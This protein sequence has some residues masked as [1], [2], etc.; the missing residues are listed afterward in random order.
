MN[1]LLDALKSHK[2]SKKLP[3]A[4]RPVV[5]YIEPKDVTNV[6]DKTGELKHTWDVTPMSL[7]NLAIDL[8][9]EEKVVDGVLTKAVE[10][11]RL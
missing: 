11:L 9:G 2:W 6:I 3:F 5:Q 7:A 4:R 1:D 10:S 8:V